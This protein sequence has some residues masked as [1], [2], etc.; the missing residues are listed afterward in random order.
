MD[1]Y[2]APNKVRSDHYY[3]H[4]GLKT[5]I[6][7]TFCYENYLDD[8]PNRNHRMYLSKLRLSNHSLL[9]ETGCHVRPV[10]PRDERWYPYRGLARDV[11]NDIY[12]RSPPYW[13]NSLFSA[14]ISIKTT[15]AA[16]KKYLQ[17]G[18][19]PS[20]TSSRDVIY[21]W[22]LE[23]LKMRYILNSEMNT[24]K[25]R[26]PIWWKYSQMKIYFFIY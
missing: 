18:G 25:K 16:R 26:K 14:V 20:M 7:S 24:W 6:K 15:R 10:I 12:R 3:L 1:I 5:C 19:R 21:H 2:T 4:I 13:T 8:I 9:I 23:R 17:Y 22:G 11:I